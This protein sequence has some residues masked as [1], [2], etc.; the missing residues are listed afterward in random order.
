[1][2]V[3][4]LAELKEIV[5]LSSV[6]YNFSD[7]TISFSKKLIIVTPLSTLFTTLA[8][9]TTGKSSDYYATSELLVGSAYAIWFLVLRT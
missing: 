5:E 7:C 8:I 3:L 4:A 1:M 6:T 9:T 2:L